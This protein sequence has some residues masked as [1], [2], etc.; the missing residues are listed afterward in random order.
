MFLSNSSE[1]GNVLGIHV[2]PLLFFAY[3]SETYEIGKENN[4][5]TSCY[6]TL[7]ERNKYFY[8]LLK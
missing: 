3:E 2:M 7:T 8:H 4:L 5:T 1:N 6:V